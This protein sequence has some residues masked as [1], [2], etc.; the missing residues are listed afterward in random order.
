MR[1]RP[2]FKAS[3]AVNARTES[4]TMLMVKVPVTEVPAEE[5]KAAEKVAVPVAPAAAL[6]V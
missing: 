2:T 1:L 5:V 3:G 6:A 4:L